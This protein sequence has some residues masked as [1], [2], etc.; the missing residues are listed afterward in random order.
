MAKFRIQSKQYQSRIPKE[1]G[2]KN[3]YTLIEDSRE[4]YDWERDLVWGA[5]L[6]LGLYLITVMMFS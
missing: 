4:S 1:P 3:D 5:L 6:A 2:W